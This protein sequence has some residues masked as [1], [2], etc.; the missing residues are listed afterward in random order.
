[1]YGHLRAIRALGRL[2]ADTS[3]IADAL[4]LTVNQ[5]NLAIKSLQRK[6]VKVL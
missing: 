3:E 4:S 5:V 2:K 6:G 1:M